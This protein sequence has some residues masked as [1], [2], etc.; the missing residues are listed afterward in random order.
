[1]DKEL[2]AI[3]FAVNEKA[4]AAR[5]EM[6]NYINNLSENGIEKYNFNW[7]QYQAFSEVYTMLSN[8]QARIIKDSL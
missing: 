2:D 8:V 7:G 6:S 1:M 5:I 4:E 3:M